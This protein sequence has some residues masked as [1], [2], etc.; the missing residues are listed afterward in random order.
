MPQLQLPIFPE[1]VTLI[2]NEIA[3]QCKDGVVTYFYG[4]L[5]VF[6]HGKEDLNCFR[7]F[8]SQLIIN[9]SVR[10]ADIVR[11]FAIPRVTVKRNVK[12]M[13]QQGAKG[14]FVPPRRRSASVLRGEVG[15]RAQA[16]LDAGN[17]VS[18]VG[19]ELEV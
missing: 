13:R 18:K 4:H 2:T 14:F 15:S 1:G 10:Q 6:Q 8:T 3:F 11:A 7:F 12:L 16:L 5:P 19:R 17:S 9:G